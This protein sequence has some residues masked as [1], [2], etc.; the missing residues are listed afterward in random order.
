MKIFLISVSLLAAFCAAVFVFWYKQI[1]YHVERYDLTEKNVYNAYCTYDVPYVIPVVITTNGITS[2]TMQTQYTT[3]EGHQDQR[4]EFWKE[5]QWYRD[6][7]ILIEDKW[8][9][10]AATTCR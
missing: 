8:Q 3:Y 6:G 5:K 1:P 7:K 4:Q 10:A 2:V 9:V